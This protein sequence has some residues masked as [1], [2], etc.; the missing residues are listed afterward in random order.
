MPR[1]EKGYVMDAPDGCPE[2]VYNVMKQCWIL[3]PVVRPCFRL[4]K[5]TMENIRAK[6]L[7]L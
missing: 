7:Y 1:V 2:A 6:E 3:D 4:L 5:E